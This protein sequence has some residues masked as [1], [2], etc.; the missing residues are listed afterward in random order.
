PYHG[1][2]P[3]EDLWSTVVGVVGNQKT[4]SVYQEMNWI[5]APFIY[6]PLTQSP[7]PEATVAIRTPVPEAIGATVQRLVAAIDPDVPLANVQTMRQ[8]ISS[9][10]AY[11]QFRAVHVE[12]VVRR[13][14]RRSDDARFHRRAAAD[15]RVG[16]DVH[17]GAACDERRS[18][19]CASI[20][21]S[22]TLE[23]LRR[24]EVG[25]RVS[26]NLE[27]GAPVV[28]GQVRVSSAR[29]AARQNLEHPRVDGA[30]RRR[31]QS[32]E[33]RGVDDVAA[34]IPHQTAHQV[35]LRER[36]AA[37][38]LRNPRLEMLREA[39]TRGERYRQSRLA[40]EEQVVRELVDEMTD[41][42]VR[43]RARAAAA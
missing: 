34:R 26:Q 35:E 24:R 20:G 14:G 18:D 32:V 23:A 8:R 1:Q 42:P 29:I 10:L 19:D 28:A 30:L 41:V 9:D 2:E 22:S 12:P 37:T 13:E 7:P 38:I 4:L 33:C 15:A 31:R 5:D 11:P 40:D 3:C 27:D 25:L 36:P 17:S 39:G 16:R 43:R 6:R 21:I